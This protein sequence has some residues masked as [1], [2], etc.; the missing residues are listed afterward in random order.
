MPYEA[1][2]GVILWNRQELGLRAPIV[3]VSQ[4]AQKTEFIV[5]HTGGEELGR[6]D[7]APWWRSIY[8][9]HTQ[10]N[11]WNDIGYNFGVATDRRMPGIAHVLEGRGWKGIGAHT[12]NH[13][14][15]GLGVV[16]LRNGAP[17]DAIK[18]A[19]RFL[20]DDASKPLGRPLEAFAHCDVYATECPGELR[21]WVHDGMHIER[22]TTLLI[23]KP[24]CCILPTPTGKG[25]YVVSTDGGVF[26]YG[27]AVFYGS[28]ADKPL[29]RP[30]SD[31]VMHP[32]GRGYWLLGEDGGVFAFGAAEFFGAPTAGRG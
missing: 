29:N 24:A 8:D 13:N 32:T 26:S 18:R 16:Y 14:T 4:A 6:V 3:P 9:F 7:F 23:N 12:L 21:D 1:A 28:L 19:I 2:P 31:A 25:Y 11:H 22:P 20:Y 27:D 17:T 5:H 15:N 30:I 10:H